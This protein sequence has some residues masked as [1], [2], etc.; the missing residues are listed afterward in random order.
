MNSISAS[1]CAAARALVGWSQDELALAAQVSRATI[2]NFESNTRIEPSQRNLLSIVA[3]LEQKGVMFIPEDVERG[4]GAGV[5]LRKLEL[6]YSSALR[7]VIR[8]AGWDLV[9]PVRYKGQACQVTIPR[10]IIDDIAR[11]NFP[12][13]AEQVKVVQSRLPE[14]LKAVESRL[15]QTAAVPAEIRLVWEDFPVGTF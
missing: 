2:A 6:E 12:T 13:T 11:G 9:F 15:S 4:L 7:T 1:Q 8:G 5:R 14:F 3:S 10:E